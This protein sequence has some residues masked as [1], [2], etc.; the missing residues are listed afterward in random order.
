MEV[1]A[2]GADTSR[3]TFPNGVILH[4]VA[5]GKRHNFPSLIA[6]VFVARHSEAPFD[7][8]EGAEFLA[9][10]A[11]IGRAVPDLPLVIKLHTPSALIADIDHGLV[12]LRAKA[13][14]VFGSMLRLKKPRPYWRHVRNSDFELA[15]LARADEVT[16]PCAAMVERLKPLWHLDPAHVA[17]IPNV[18]IPAPALLDTPVDTET[19]TVSFFGRLEARKGVL[20]FAQ[21]VPRVLDAVPEARFRFVGRSNPHPVTRQDIGEILR[22]AL[23][24][25]AERVEWISGLPYEEAIALYAHTD[26]CIF[27]SIWENFPNVALEAMAAARGVVGSS[28]GGMAEMIDHGRT[29]LLVPPQS[30]KEAAAAVITLLRNRE[31]RMEMGRAARAH[32]LSAYSPEAIAPLQEAVYARAIARAKARRAAA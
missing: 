25:Y 31:H 17:I 19:Q 1:F 26:I 30:P 2:A 3:Q 32:V 21:I 7:V 22:E 16:S 18:F 10:A 12:P 28:A 8:A 23:A 13:R 9:E 11:D 29:G 27:P 6:P 5:A 4:T 15:S 14:F 24:G 20:D